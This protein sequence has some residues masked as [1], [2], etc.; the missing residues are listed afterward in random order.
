MQEDAIQ[1]AGRPL[2]EEAIRRTTDRIAEIKANPR[3]PA[4]SSY[5]GR[6]PLGDF[7]EIER[8]ILRTLQDLFTVA[9]R[10]S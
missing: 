8:R 7:L 5:V 6:V 9:R 3:A 10:E 1:I 4:G 2:I